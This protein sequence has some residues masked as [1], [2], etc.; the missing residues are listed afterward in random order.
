MILLRAFLWLLFVLVLPGC[1]DTKS[2]SSS[3]SPSHIL[4]QSYSIS[5]PFSRSL[6]L[7]LSLVPLRLR[8][9]KHSNISPKPTKSEFGVAP[10]GSTRKRQNAWRKG[11]LKVSFGKDSNAPWEGLKQKLLQILA[12]APPHLACRCAARRDPAPA[13]TACA[14]SLVSFDHPTIS[15]SLAHPI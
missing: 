15:M 11:F 4:S 14:R 7:P 8:L 13:P 10:C 3:V 9:L 2:G 1:L 12:S 6:S 5:L